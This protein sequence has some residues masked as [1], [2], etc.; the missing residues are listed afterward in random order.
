MNFIYEE[1]CGLVFGVTAQRYYIPRIYMMLSKHSKETNFFS[2]GLICV[3]FR[4]GP[5]MVDMHM[6][7]QSDSTEQLFWRI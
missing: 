7:S 6:F 2:L 5:L 1:I 4:L 3:F